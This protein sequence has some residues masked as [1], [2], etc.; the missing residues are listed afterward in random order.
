MRMSK[1]T[2]EVSI[3]G[4]VVGVYPYDRGTGGSYRL[5]FKTVMQTKERQ[6]VDN[7]VFVK[8][9]NEVPNMDDVVQIT[10]VLNI[11]NTKNEAT[12][13]YDVNVSI[14]EESRGFIKKG[15]PRAK[16][17]FTKSN[18]GAKP[19]YTKKESPKPD[20]GDLD[21]VNDIPF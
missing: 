9:R 16:K 11:T 21:D 13:K 12:G 10:G 5:V 19:S 2:N 4:Q 3:T 6:I 8:T 20:F 1:A 17:P 14:L 7:Y 18:N 15:E